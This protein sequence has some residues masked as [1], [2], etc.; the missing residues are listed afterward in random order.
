MTD[1]C[2]HVFDGYHLYFTSSCAAEAFP[3]YASKNR[4]R[5][6]S[7]EFFIRN[8]G[9]AVVAEQGKEDACFNCRAASRRRPQRAGMIIRREGGEWPFMPSGTCTSP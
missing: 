5:E 1:D 7:A 3:A 2:P 6:S 8:D 9:S 4:R